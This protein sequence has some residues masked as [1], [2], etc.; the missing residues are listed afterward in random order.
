MTLAMSLGVPG[1]PHYDFMLGLITIGST[2]S[3]ASRVSPM[4]YLNFYQST[5][6]K[7][8]ALW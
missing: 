2:T 3:Q 7:D 6:D 1:V 5:G 4:Q 8:E